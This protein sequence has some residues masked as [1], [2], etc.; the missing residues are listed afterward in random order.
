MHWTDTSRGSAVSIKP[1]GD[2]PETEL[3]LHVDSKTQK[4][5]EAELPAFDVW[6]VWRGEHVCRGWNLD[7]GEKDCSYSLDK[8]EFQSVDQGGYDENI[9]DD[10]VH[11]IT[12]S[13]Q[14]VHPYEHGKIEDTYK[15]TLFRY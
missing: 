14:S 11:I 13:S 12:A 4:V 6:T 2:P 9:A 10:G 8:E 3:A 5:V 15:W 7:E 1:V